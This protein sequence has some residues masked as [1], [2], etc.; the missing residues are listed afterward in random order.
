MPGDP[1]A[2]DNPTAAMEAA[3][4]DPLSSDEHVNLINRFVQKREST[5]NAEEAGGMDPEQLAG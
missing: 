4:S 2:I 1:T 3:S 5:E